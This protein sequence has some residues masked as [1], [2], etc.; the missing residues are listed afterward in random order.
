M[1]VSCIGVSLPLPLSLKSLKKFFKPNW[2]R[3]IIKNKPIFAIVID[4]PNLRRRD[5]KYISDVIEM[6]SF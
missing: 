3:R 4:F 2:L 5:E 6:Y 1:D